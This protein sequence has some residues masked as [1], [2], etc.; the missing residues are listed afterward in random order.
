MRLLKNIYH[1]KIKVI[2]FVR[3]KCEWLK[4]HIAYEWVECWIYKRD[5]PFIS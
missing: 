4:S 3:C 2:V 1:I 5:D